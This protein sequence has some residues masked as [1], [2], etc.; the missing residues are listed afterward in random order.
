MWERQTLLLV[1]MSDWGRPWS[2][3]RTGAP[4]LDCSGCVGWCDSWCIKNS[5]GRWRSSSMSCF[6]GKA[7]QNRPREGADSHLRAC[8]GGTRRGGWSMHQLLNHFLMLC[9]WLAYFWASLNEMKCKCSWDR[10]GQHQVLWD[11]S[12][13]QWGQCLQGI[14]AAHLARIWE[15]VQM[16]HLVA[17]PPSSCAGSTFLRVPLIVGSFPIPAAVQSPCLHPRSSLCTLLHPVPGI[18]L[19]SCC[20]STCSAAFLIGYFDL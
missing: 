10:T 18:L 16:E 4:G 9:P 14:R 17:L 2:S 13:A 5:G 15:P 3:Q 6:R 19:P 12:P 7:A 1:L 8:W 20:F 11:F